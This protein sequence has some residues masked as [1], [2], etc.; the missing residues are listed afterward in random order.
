MSNGEW[1]FTSALDELGCALVVASV[2]SILWVFGR[3]HKVVTRLLNSIGVTNHIADQDIWEFMFNSDDPKIKFA[4]IRDYENELIY[5]GYV[6]AYSERSDIR[7]LAMYD[8]YVFDQKGNELYSTPYLYL[9]RLPSSITLEF[10]VKEKT[11]DQ[12]RQR[13]WTGFWAWVTRK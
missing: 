2:L 5:A 11:D 7:E 8:V 12:K 3:T 10:P 6:R 1:K 9:S 13:W 4:H